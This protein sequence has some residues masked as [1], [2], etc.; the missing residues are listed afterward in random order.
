MDKSDENSFGIYTKSISDA[1]QVGVTSWVDPCR[2]FIEQSACHEGCG[3]DLI[4]I[5]LFRLR[6]ITAQIAKSAMSHG[7]VDQ[8]MKQSEDLATWPIGTANRN[9]RHELAGERESAHFVS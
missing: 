1:T 4:A 7:Y 2:R 5:P 8:L 3:S 9:Y 6:R